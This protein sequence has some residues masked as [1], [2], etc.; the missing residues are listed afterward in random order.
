MS[1]VLSYPQ[2]GSTGIDPQTEMVVVFQ[3]PFVKQE[4]INIVVDAVPA[5]I[6][7]YVQNGF[8]TT[9]LSESEGQVKWGLRCPGGLPARDILVQAWCF[10][11][12]ASVEQRFFVRGAGVEVTHCLRDNWCLSGGAVVQGKGTPFP[13]GVFLEDC[14]IPKEAITDIMDLRAGWVFCSSSDKHT[15]LIAPDFIH[16][17]D[18][19]S[20]KIKITRDWINLKIT[21]A[22]TAH[23]PINYKPSFNEKSTSDWFE[24]VHQGRWEME[25]SNSL[26]IWWNSKEFIAKA[27]VNP[28]TG[29]SDDIL[30]TSE[31][32][33]VSSIDSIKIIDANRILVNSEY[34][35]DTHDPKVEKIC[36][37]SIQT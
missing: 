4:D 37:Q 22:R 35:V 9:R 24:I 32:V 6:D 27:N 25:F 17:Y 18:F 14:P 13:T 31:D 36:N 16:R 30:W 15:W 3:H 29:E 12:C 5:V 8:R 1:V 11:D 21:S 7:G 34:L 28:M 23:L 20:R 10:H 19:P 2:P 33:G 26:H